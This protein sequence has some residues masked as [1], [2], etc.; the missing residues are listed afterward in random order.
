MFILRFIPANFFRSGTFSIDWKQVGLV[1]ANILVAVLLSSAMVNA[2]AQTAAQA[3]TVSDPRIPGGIPGVLA[4]VVDPRVPGGLVIP[5]GTPGVASPSP[6]TPQVAAACNRINIDAASTQMITSKVTTFI[7]MNT[8]QTF[9]IA[10]KTIAGGLRPT[11]LQLAGAFV[12]LSLISALMFAMVSNKS[13]MDVIVDHLIM[14]T[15]VAVLIGNY[16]TIIDGALSLAVHLNTLIGAA[17]SPAQPIVDLMTAFFS[18]IL[19]IFINIASTCP[20]WIE[21]IRNLVDSLI[22]MAIL[23]IAFF[24][25]ISAIISIVEVIFMGPVLLGLGIAIGP[26]FIATFSTKFTK[27]FFDRWIG[28]LIGAAIL[29]FVAY[30]MLKLLTTTLNVIGTAGS[31][32]SYTGQAIGLAITMAIMGKLF[33]SVPSIVSALVPASL[34]ATGG[35]GKAGVAAAAGGV[36]M[37]APIA[38][39][40]GGAIAQAAKPV[41]SAVAA[42]GAQAAAAIKN[43]IK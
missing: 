11:A 28:F 3:P 1:F 6:A 41:L 37:A 7:Q 9:V 34:G 31:G 32:S 5:A 20:D 17:S 42:G 38:A 8:L 26:I 33:A 25:G 10:G 2:Q 22:A 13:A 16:Q 30:T 12:T 43:F 14:A 27:P 24:I 40:V 29:Q 23:L 39:P 18:A 35:G 21:I 19:N 15:I 36:A 4:P